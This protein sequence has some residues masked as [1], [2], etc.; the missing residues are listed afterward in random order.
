M[1]TPAPEPHG[2]PAAIE[3]ELAVVEREMRQRG[4]RWTV[5]RRL[6]AKAA[7]SNHSHYS[8]DELLEL[9]RDED[10]AV[11]RA[12]VYRTLSMLEE[13]GFVEGLDTGDGGRKFEHTLGHKHHDHMVCTGCGAIIEFHDEQL[14]RRQDAA[15]AAQGFE[16]QSH[17]LKLFGLCRRCRKPQ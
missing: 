16:I 3:K 15:A 14:E 8:A 17:S 5:Q 12:T 13:A 10:R 2:S 6:V 11:S 1:P 7:L 9:C 4:L